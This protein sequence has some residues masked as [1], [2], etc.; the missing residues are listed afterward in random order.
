[1][2]GDDQRPDM[3]VVAGVR[4]TTTEAMQRRTKIIQ[5]LMMGSTI[6]DIAT[7]LNITEGHVRRVLREPSTKA[8]IKELDDETLRSVARRAATF[9]PSAL[10]VLAQIM[11]SK[12]ET[13]SARVSAAGRIIDA[14]LKVAE[15]ADLAE[16]I[17]KLEDQLTTR[18]GPV[19]WRQPT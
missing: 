16:R 14:M 12:S 4:R 2:S 8:R 13:A 3:R 7:L 9:G 19:P 18:G 11:A 17:D 1:M 15:L 6:S 10:T 5:Q